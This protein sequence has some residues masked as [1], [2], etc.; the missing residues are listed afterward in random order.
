MEG[1]MAM[2]NL[3]AIDQDGGKTEVNTLQNGQFQI[4]GM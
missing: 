1:Y 4:L 2:H 3:E